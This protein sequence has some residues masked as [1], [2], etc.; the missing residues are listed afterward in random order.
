MCV[1][2]HHVYLSLCISACFLSIILLYMLGCLSIHCSVFLSSST[3]FCINLSTSHIDVRLSL[4]LPRGSSCVSFLHH[5]YLPVLFLYFTQHAFL[6]SCCLILI[7]YSSRGLH[8]GTCTCASHTYMY[9]CLVFSHE[10]RLFRT[11]PAHHCS[12]SP[13]LEHFHISIII[14]LTHAYIHSPVQ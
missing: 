13:A 1:S 12:P 10:A 9:M 5:V 2:L 14:P 8:L 7:I 3:S 4:C 11:M 6:F